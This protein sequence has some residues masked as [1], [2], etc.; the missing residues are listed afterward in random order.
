[1]PG[2]G[3]SGKMSGMSGADIATRFEQANAR[4][5]EVVLGPAREHW[6]TTT[7]EEGW[8][9]GV[10][11]R[12]IALGHD[13]MASWAQALADGAERL[14]GF[15]IH[16]QNAAIAAEGVVASP[17]QVAELLQERGPALA[18]ALRGLTDDQ[19]AGEIDFGG[20]AMPRAMLAEAAVRHVEGHLASIGAVVD[21][22]V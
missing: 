17:D 11:A 12:H 21:A 4:A 2:T 18:A 8:P 22:K 3:G 20:R 5:I 15:D 14:D 10:T 9:V 13:L 19:L 1:M 16:A 6:E 7:S